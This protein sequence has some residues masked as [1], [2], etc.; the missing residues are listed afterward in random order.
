MNYCKKPILLFETIK[1][2]N[3]IACNLEFHLKRVQSSISKR[4]KFDINEVLKTTLNGLLRAK[5]IYDEDGNFKDIRFFE[6]K[7][8]QISSLKFINSNLNYEKKYLNRN[9]ID[10]IFTMRGKCDEVLIV[11]NGQIADTSIANVAAKFNNT[12]YTPKSAILAGTTRQRLLESGFLKEMDFGIDELK[13]A[14]KFA[15]MNAMIDFCEFDISALDSAIL[16]F[17][18]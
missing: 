16:T 3:K 15:L 12:W 6:Y 2:E 1:I 8:R 5:L 10:R 18:S 7:I 17:N 13:N 4:I 14:Q 9:E 11:K